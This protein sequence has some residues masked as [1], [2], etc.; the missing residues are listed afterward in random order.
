MRSIAAALLKDD[1]V[2]QILADSAARH[3]ESALRFVNS[4]HYAGEHWL[5]SFAVLLLS[6]PSPE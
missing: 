1:P 3:A 2:R 4:G 5:A 6:T